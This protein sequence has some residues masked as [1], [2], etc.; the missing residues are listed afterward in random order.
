MFHLIPHR[1]FPADFEQRYRSVWVDPPRWELADAE[2]FDQYYNRTL[3]ELTCAAGAGPDGLCV[4][5]HHQNAY[6]FMRGPNLMGSALARATNGQ[7]VAIVQM[8]AALPTTNP[9]IRYA[10]LAGSS[11]PDEADGD[12]P[13]STRYI[14]GHTGPH[15]LPSMEIQALINDPAA[16]RAYLEGALN[17]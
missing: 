15:R 8:G 12:P 6:G 14:T 9:T 5:E 1:D 4:N 2:R 16:F 10:E 13:N 11:E 7:D 3:D 17:D